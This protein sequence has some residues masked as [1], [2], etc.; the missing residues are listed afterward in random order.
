MILIVASDSPKNLK[1]TS[2]QLIGAFFNCLRSCS[3]D[4]SAPEFPKLHTS[5][6]LKKQSGTFNEVSGNYGFAFDKRKVRSNRFVFTVSAFISRF[7]D[8][9][10]TLPSSKSILL[11]RLKIAES[12]HNSIKSVFTTTLPIN[13]SESSS[14]DSIIW[15]SSELMII[16]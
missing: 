11:E 12:L 16:S 4:K 6:S 1:V 14:S 5:D 3:L 10:L 7:F 15:A 13:L 2:L 9:A 8:R